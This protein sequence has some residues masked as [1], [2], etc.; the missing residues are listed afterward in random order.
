MSFAQTIIVGNIGRAA[1]VRYSADG[2][3]VCNFSVAVNE[4]YTK[5]GERVETT[6]WYRC[7]AYRRT[8]EIA[9]EYGAK[10]K[11]VLIRGK[12]KTRSFE[13][14]GET[15]YV[16]ELVVHE[17]QLRGGR[18]SGQQSDTSA[19]ARQPSAREQA[20]QG[21]AS[22]GASN[23]MEMDD[24]IPFACPRGLILYSL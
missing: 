20:G 6:E 13:K 16:T 9:G 10:G 8:A 5:N 22:R 3:A 12:M 23:I 18:D 19:P 1:E 11:E 7:V 24:D 21:G 4:T 14:D 17:F 2:N 15:K